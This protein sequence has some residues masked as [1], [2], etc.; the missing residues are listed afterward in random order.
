MIGLRIL[1]N[2]KFNVN[3]VHGYYIGNCDRIENIIKTI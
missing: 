1:L 3:E 2:G